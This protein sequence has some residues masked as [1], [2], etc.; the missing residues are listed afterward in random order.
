M[1][2]SVGPME[3]GIVLVVALLVFGPRKLPELGGSIGKGIREFTRS[4]AGHSDEKPALADA[5]AVPRAEAS[6]PAADS[7]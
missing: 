4:V 1:V 3:I 6:A 5:A 7:S 2:G